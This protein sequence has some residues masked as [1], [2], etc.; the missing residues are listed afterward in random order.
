MG[1]TMHQLDISC[2]QGKAPVAEMGYILLSHWPKGAHSHPNV[3]GY[4]QC[5]WLSPQPDGKILLLQIPFT[6][7]IKPSKIRASKR[8]FTTT[9]QYSQCW[10]VLY[11]LQE[12]KNNH[13]SNPA[14]NPID[15]QQ[16][17][18]HW[19]NDGI[20]VMVITTLFLKK[21]PLRPTISWNAYLLK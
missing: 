13:Y 9:V 18:A 7:P 3:T 21:L 11:T 12:D 19:C 14:I 2:Y 1:E 4:C 17:F 6:Y 5:F 20:N 16:Q 15:L 10:K 8:S